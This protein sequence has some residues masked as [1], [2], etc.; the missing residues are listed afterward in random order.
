MFYLDASVLVA[1]YTVE[2][3]SER[4]LA[5][6]GSSTRGALAISEWTIT[7]FASAM[8]IKI[9]TGQIGIEGRNT[10][11]ADFTVMAEDS[12]LILTIDGEHFRA[13]TQLVKQH[14]TGLR[15]GDALHLAVAN[16]NGATV[17]TLDKRMAEAGTI[18]GMS[19]K[20]L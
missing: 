3:H 4:A 2:A 12:L 13:A 7:E 5:W 6:L 16:A 11:L 15:A 17:C 9:R 14:T 8:S 19:T 18:L 1:A 10:A 20:L